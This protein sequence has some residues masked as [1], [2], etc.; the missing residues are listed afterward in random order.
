MFWDLLTKFQKIGPDSSKVPP[1]NFKNISSQNGVGLYSSQYGKSNFVIKILIL[2]F[3][4]FLYF[5]YAYHYNCYL[6]IF[7]LKGKQNQENSYGFMWQLPD[8]PQ[9]KPLRCSPGEQ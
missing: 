7:S 4:Y 1:Q 2:K 3:L 5:F 6:F 9:D 8:S